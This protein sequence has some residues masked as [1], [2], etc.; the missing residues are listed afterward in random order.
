MEKDIKENWYNGLRCFISYWIAKFYQICNPILVI[1]IIGELWM[2]FLFHLSDFISPFQT[3]EGCINPIMVEVII[4]RMGISKDE[5]SKPI[6]SP[7]Y[8]KDFSGLPPTTFIIGEYDGIR[9]DSEAY[10]EKVKQAGNKV[11]RILLP[12][13]THNVMVMRKAMCDGE[14]PAEVV[15]NV[16][17]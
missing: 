17:T 4:E 8:E 1:P 3:A 15:A 2:D 6:F 11:D 9:S 13:Q 16:I 14:D 5:F 7:Y 10:Y 12:G